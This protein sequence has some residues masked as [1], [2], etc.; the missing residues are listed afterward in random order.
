MKSLIKSGAVRTDLICG[1]IDSDEGMEEIQ[2]LSK[3]LNKKISYV[4][5]AKIYDD[6]FRSIR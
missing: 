6:L 4:C 3:T 2:E 1:L 5:S